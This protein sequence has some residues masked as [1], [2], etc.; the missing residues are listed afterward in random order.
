MIASMR[1]KINDFAGPP[2]DP[3]STRPT[4]RPA[5]RLSD[6]LIDSLTDQLTN[7][8]T[9]INVNQTLTKLTE[10]PETT[11]LSYWDQETKKEREKDGPGAVM[12]SN[13]ICPAVQILYTGPGPSF[14]YT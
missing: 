8:F 2:S 11:E 4:H 9:N 5:Y 10:L 6:R 12:V 14:F 3:T 1:V 7:Q 13:I